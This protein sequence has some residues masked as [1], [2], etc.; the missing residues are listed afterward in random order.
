MYGLPPDIDL[1]YFI[2]ATLHQAC[3]GAN[4]LILRFDQTISVTIESSFLV[5]VPGLN[6]EHFDDIRSS[7]GKIVR[8]IELTVVNATGASDG[9]LTLIFDGGYR[10]DVYDSSSRYESYQIEHDSQVT[11]I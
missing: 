4:E 3:F 2:G 7:A 1:T 6:Q 9:T 10:I 11:V 5:S 8:L